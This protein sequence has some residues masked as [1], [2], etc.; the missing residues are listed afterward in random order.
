MD[1]PRPDLALGPAEAAAGH[2]RILEHGAR[3]V[4]GGH[5]SRSILSISSC[6]GGS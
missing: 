1:N 3:G 6:V 2:D 4:D 5:S